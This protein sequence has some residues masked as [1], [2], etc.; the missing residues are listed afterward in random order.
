MN[1]FWTRFNTVTDAA[2]M[3]SDEA[4]AYAQIQSIYVAL[5]MIIVAL[6]SMIPTR[7]LYEKARDADYD[8]VMCWSSLLAINILVTITMC[9]FAAVSILMEVMLFM[10]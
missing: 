1:E 9:T 10:T 4:I 5:M 7:R 3:V 8:M 6:V 2:L